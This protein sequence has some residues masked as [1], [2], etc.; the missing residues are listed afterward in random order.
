[1][2]L[3]LYKPRTREEKQDLFLCLWLV[4]VVPCLK[5]GG[6][7]CQRFFCSS[8]SL[9]L[10]QSCRQ[11]QNLPEELGAVRSEGLLESMGV[12]A[13]DFPPRLVPAT[14]REMCWEVRS[15][16]EGRIWMKISL[17]THRLAFAAAGVCCLPHL[18]AGLWASFP[19]YRILGRMGRARLPGP[20]LSWSCWCCS[21]PPLTPRSLFRARLWKRGA[22]CGSRLACSVFI[23]PQLSLSS[24][25][26]G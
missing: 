23:R 15:V 5:Q 10:V 25:S 8:S 14:S 7:I 3:V 18:F 20:C 13:S 21:G 2:A 16:P 19:T 22:P 12:E 6:Q 1:M 9:A 4:K 17:L 11:L 26:Q 24:Q